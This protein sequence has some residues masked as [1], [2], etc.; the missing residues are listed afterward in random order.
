MFSFSSTV[1]N[2]TLRKL[3]ELG[4][5]KTKVIVSHNKE[6][7]GEDGTLSISKFAFVNYH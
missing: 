5:V 2:I 7:V 3:L 4:Q 6:M 1:N